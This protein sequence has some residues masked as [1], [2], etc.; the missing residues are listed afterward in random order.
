MIAASR[1]TLDPLA[2]WPV[3]AVIGALSVLV[4]VMYLSR[5]GKSWLLRALGMT[6][7]G[8]ALLNPLLVREQREPL[9]D[10]VALV[11]DRSES[12]R[13]AGRTEAADAAFETLRAQLAAD[14]DIELRITETPPGAAGTEI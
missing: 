10:I 4:W 9:K 3:L 12:M 14:D 5:G 8:V 11:R 6:V 7:L 13:F 1:F 2:S